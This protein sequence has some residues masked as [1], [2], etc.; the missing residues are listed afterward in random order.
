M[1]FFGKIYSQPVDEPVVI[2]HFSTES[3]SNG[4]GDEV[5]AA[6][7]GFGTAP[8]AQKKGWFNGDDHGIQQDLMLFDGIEWDFRWDLMEFHGI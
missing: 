6:W 3:T 8:T 7:N 1:M 2:P 5:A 4:P